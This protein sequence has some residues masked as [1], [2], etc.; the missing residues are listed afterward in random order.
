MEFEK[1]KFEKEGSLATITLNR[2]GKLNAFTTAM[3]QELPRLIKTVQDDDD[4]RVL[5]LTGSGKGFCAG[6]DINERLKNRISGEKI[7]TTRK[8]LLEPVG[9]LAFEMQNLNKQD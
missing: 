7:E 8:D 9:Y 3:W 4:I 1:I 6:S 2:P 5:I